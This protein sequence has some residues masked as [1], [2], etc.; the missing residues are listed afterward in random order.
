[1]LLMIAQPDIP[2]ALAWSHYFR[3]ESGLEPIQ[4]PVFLCQVSEKYTKYIWA[5][6]QFS[7]LKRLQESWRGTF[8]KCM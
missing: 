1:M 7:P 3:R 5:L 4:L 6:C 8:Y 2:S